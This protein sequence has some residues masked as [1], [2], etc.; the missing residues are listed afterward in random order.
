MP[1]RK[2]PRRS[3]VSASR[4]SPEPNGRPEPTV[5]AYRFAGTSRQPSGC[6]KAAPSNLVDMCIRV[7]ADWNWEQR[8][9]AVVSIPSRSRPQLIESVATGL[10]TA[11]KLPYLG[12]LD[13][14]GTGP[15]GDPG[16][17]SAYRLASVW[18]A[19]AVPSTFP[20]R[21]PFPEALEGDTPGNPSGPIL[22]ID[23]LADSRWTLTVASRELLRAGASAV[24]PFTLAL[25]G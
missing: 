14:V 23:D 20:G 17:N 24:L 6:S 11:G 12:P 22:L 16:G 15:T 21:S 8:P 19:F 13:L 10:A 25:R 5:S 3:T 4:S 2:P 18:G 1:Q 7:L 9:V